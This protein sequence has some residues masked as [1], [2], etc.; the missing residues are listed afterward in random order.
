M[1]FSLEYLSKLS[2]MQRKNFWPIS[3]LALEDVEEELAGPIVISLSRLQRK[4]K[5]PVVV[6]LL[7]MQNPLGPGLCIS[8]HLLV[9]V[10]FAKQKTYVERQ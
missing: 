3:C 6:S 8:L 5:Q 7:R 10:V 2:R 4:N 1:T 9:I